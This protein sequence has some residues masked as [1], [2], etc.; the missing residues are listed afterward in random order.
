LTGV[1]ICAHGLAKELPS[2]R[3][4]KIYLMNCGEVSCS[5]SKRDFFQPGFIKEW[6]DA[7][8]N[9]ETDGWHSLDFGELRKTQRAETPVQRETEEC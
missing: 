3:G 6:I 5:L 9:G 4:V 2:Y 1:G 8:L 7:A